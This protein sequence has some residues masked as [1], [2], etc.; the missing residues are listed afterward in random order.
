MGATTIKQ[1]K[2]DVKWAL[3]IVKIREIFMFYYLK[4][5]Q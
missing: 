4:P 2:K 1:T 5:W 3:K